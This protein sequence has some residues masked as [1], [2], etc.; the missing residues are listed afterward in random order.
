MI[1]W[2]QIGLHISVFAVLGQLKL[3]KN[4]RF[5]FLQQNI[6]FENNTKGFF[7]ILWYKQSSM[8]ITNYTK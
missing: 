2:P 8:M 6:M 3:L 7:W 4:N 1:D 5:T